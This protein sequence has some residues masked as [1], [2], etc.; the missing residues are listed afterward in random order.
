MKTIETVLSE[1]L[2]MSAS[3]IRSVIPTEGDPSGYSP[4]IPN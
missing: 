1:P 2:R 3:C 4:Q